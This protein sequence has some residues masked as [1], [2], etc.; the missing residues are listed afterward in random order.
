M[1]PLRWAEGGFLLTLTLL[2]FLYPAE[3]A[4]G[5]RQGLVLC[6]DLLIPA[7]FPFFVLSSLPR[8]GRG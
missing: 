1:K 3:S 8:R 7:L 4:A 5:A 2:L 6:R